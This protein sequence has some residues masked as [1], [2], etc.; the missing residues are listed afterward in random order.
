MQIDRPADLTEIAGLGMTLS[1]AKRL[2]AC[3]QQEIAAAQSRDHAV[4]RPYCSHCDGAC[5]VKD[6]RDPAVATLFGQVMVRLPRSHSTACR[7]QPRRRLLAR[8]A[9]RRANG[10]WRSGS[11][12]SK[13]RLVAARFSAPSPKPPRTSELQ[14]AGPLTL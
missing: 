11:A 9:A 6:Y 2:L 8:A 5:R 1:E 3:V 10:I 13:L 7:K 12:M 14:S 4:P